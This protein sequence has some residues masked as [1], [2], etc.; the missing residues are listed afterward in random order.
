MI[1]N[2]NEAENL[3][4][5]Y[6]VNK[7]FLGSF[8]GKDVIKFVTNKIYPQFF[9]NYGSESSFPL[10]EKY[11]CSV[12]FVDNSYNIIL[13][14]YLESPFMGNIE[15]LM[16]L[17]NGISKSND[18]VKLELNNIS[19]VSVKT[20][21]TKILKQLSY[22]FLNYSLRLISQITE[23]IKDDN[24]KNLLKDSLV[25]YSVTIVHKLNMFM[26]DEI[27]EKTFLF[28]SLRDDLIRIGN[29]KIDIYKKI[30]QLEKKINIQSKE[31][32]ELI[33]KISNSDLENLD[34]NFSMSASENQNI[35]TNSSYMFNDSDCYYTESGHNENINYL[36]PIK[37]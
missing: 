11:I 9:E 20:N 31:V 6:S 13:L 32:N 1:I 33:L 10:I 28:K 7:I 19:D 2:F 36:S 24:S 35:D 17:Y 16:K 29:L 23:K 15:M 18:I 5:V 37:E 3:F 21:I 14:N 12:N 22:V 8:S 34:V 30:D 25:K 4:S 26:R 27:E